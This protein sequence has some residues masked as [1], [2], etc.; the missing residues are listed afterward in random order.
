MKNNARP[1]GSGS[2]SVIIKY[3]LVTIVFLVVLLVI[4]NF[5]LPMLS[6]DETDNEVNTNGIE[7]DINVNNEELNG[8]SEGDS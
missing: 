5:L 6:D 7:V 3:T 8:N 1:G 4:F 2:R